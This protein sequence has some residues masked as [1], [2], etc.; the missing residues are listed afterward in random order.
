MPVA[1]MTVAGAVI[2]VTMVAPL[3]EAAAA[4]LVVPL[5]VTLVEVEAAVILVEAPSKERLF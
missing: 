1:V 3:A 2:V 4:I 5:V